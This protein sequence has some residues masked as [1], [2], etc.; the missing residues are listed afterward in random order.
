MRFKY[1]VKFVDE[2]GSIAAARDGTIY[3]SSDMRNLCSRQ[4]DAIILHEQ[5]HL[6]HEDSLRGAWRALAAIACV[7]V[8]VTAVH[9]TQ[10]PWAV[11]V[12]TAWGVAWYL[13]TLHANHQAEYLADAYV[14]EH[15]YGPDLQA[16]LARLHSYTGF[17]RASHSHPAPSDRVRRMQRLINGEA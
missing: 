4:L 10:S 15:D 7:I 1:P 6:E 9:V 13:F 14:V 11:F 17:Y 5:G 3:V 2:C 8:L 16:A 12:A